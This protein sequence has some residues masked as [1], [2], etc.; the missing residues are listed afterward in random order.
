MAY[1]YTAEIKDDIRSYISN[2]SIEPKDYESRDQMYEALYDNLWVDDSVTGN[3]SGSYTFNSAKAENNLVG[4]RDLLSDAM[5]EFGS[6]STEDW[7]KAALMPEWADVVIRC[8][9]LGEALGTVLNEDYKDSDFGSD[10][11]E[12]DDEE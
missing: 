2:N 11:N 3:G 9:L 8:Y 6:N 1:D 4:N 10:D 7:K 12:D 5:D